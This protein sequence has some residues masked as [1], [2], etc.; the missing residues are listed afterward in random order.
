MP[1][2]PISQLPEGNT[3]Q[4]DFLFVQVDSNLS[5]TQKV[6][7]DTV[8]QHSRFYNP[9]LNFEVTSGNQVVYGT[10]DYGRQQKCWV[11]NGPLSLLIN[12]EPLNPNF[13]YDH[14]GS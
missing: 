12:N 11:A 4:L 10:G 7:F 1:D 3:V 2:L 14:R 9:T 13:N 6:T 5:T 8:V